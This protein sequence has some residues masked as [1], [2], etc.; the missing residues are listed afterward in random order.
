[1]SKPISSA[2]RVVL[3]I[4]SVLLLLLFFNLTTPLL[5][6]ILPNSFKKIDTILKDLDLM[7]QRDTAE[8]LFFGASQVGW[9]LN[10]NIVEDYL[11]ETAHTRRYEAMNFSGGAQSIQGSPFYFTKL[12]SNVNV[13]VQCL[14]LANLSA[15]PEPDI[16]Q[17]IAFSMYNYKLDKDIE[18]ILPQDLYAP[19]NKP[20]LLIN[21]EARNIVKATMLSLGVD[22]VH[23][24]SHTE[25]DRWN[26]NLKWNNPTESLRRTT[27]TGNLAAF[28]KSYNLSN[29]KID[30][31]SKN[32]IINARDYL[33]SKGIVYILVISPM[34]PAVTAAS[35][36]EVAYALHTFKEAFYSLP[37]LDCYSLLEADDFY[38]IPHPN[39]IGARKFSEAAAAY[40]AGILG[41]AP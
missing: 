25:M 3:S 10:A 32:I 5:Y 12:P 6:Q 11:N 30:P 19:L 38:D 16:S 24:F 17:L 35:E 9:G 29:Y 20:R 41:D 14:F 37:V 33:A 7:A 34:S 8:I 27:Y 21:Y 18:A 15:A 36:E 1:M 13:V 22:I 40:L 26:T 31:V 23:F 2:R 4:L 28:N 39:R